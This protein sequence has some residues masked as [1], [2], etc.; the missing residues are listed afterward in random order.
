R[1]ELCTK[2]GASLV[3]G[4]MEV[5]GDPAYVRAACEASLR[6]LD[7]N[8]IDL[9]YQHRIDTS[10]PI[11]ITMGELKKLVEE[12]KIKY[13]GLSE[14]S[15]STIRRAHAVH[16]ITA[17]QLEWSLWTRDAEEEIIPTCRELGIGIVAYSPLGRGFFSSGA[18]MTENLT[19][20]DIL[21]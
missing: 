11:E 4:N 7:T 18:K 3:S 19:E 6:R 8:C 17:V 2:F 21:K 10:V 9:Y 15:A 12:G 16:P 13:V 5:H 14:A 1:V 20:N